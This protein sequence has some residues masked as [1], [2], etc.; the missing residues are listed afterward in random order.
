MSYTDHL[1]K[2]KKLALTLSNAPFKLKQEKKVYLHLCGSIMSQQLSTKVAAVIWKR[3]LGLYEDRSPTPEQILATPND[4][5]RG[6]GLSNAKVQYIQNVA[7]FALEHGME[8]KQLKKMSDD[9][10]IDH[11]IQIKGVGRWT[12]EMLLMF[13]LGREDVF[14]VDD[15]GIQQAMIKL[16]KLDNFNKKEFKE[17]MLRIAAKWSPYRTYACLHLWKW[18]DLAV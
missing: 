14:A 8:W 2:D 16:Y 4:T 13:A 1:A 18:K 5:L 12:I 9:E 11:L 17:K 7:R 6:I 15:L 3:F 10:V